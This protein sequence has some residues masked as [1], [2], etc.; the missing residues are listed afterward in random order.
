MRLIKV[1]LIA[2]IVLFPGLSRAEAIPPDQLMMSATNK[3]I[4]VIKND[5]DIQSGNLGKLA[6]VVRE[7]ILPHIDLDRV[8][9]GILGKHWESA[10]SAQRDA[11]KAEFATFISYLYATQL[12]DYHDQTVRFDLPEG[13]AD[14]KDFVITMLI[15]ESGTLPEKAYFSVGKVGDEWKIYDINAGGISFL[16]T[17]RGQF[18]PLVKQ[19]GM[20]V[21]IQK[22]VEKNQRSQSTVSVA[23][24]NPK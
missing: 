24:A 18:V 23:V 10:S 20:D 7:F 15:L 8:S 2:A 11:F 19:S 21:L 3:V 17:Y 14:T 1:A 5:K 13:Y 6:G 9:K 22:L 12:P 4:E 16:T